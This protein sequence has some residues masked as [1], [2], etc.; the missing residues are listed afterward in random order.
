VRNSA[1]V[2][3]IVTSKAS[4]RVV[5]SGIN[6]V[7]SA[8]RVNSSAIRRDVVGVHPSLLG[9]AGCGGGVAGRDVCVSGCAVRS[10]T[11]AGGSS[12]VVVGAQAVGA[13]AWG[14]GL[15]G[16]I[17]RG[18]VRGGAVVGGSVV[19]G[20]GGGLSVVVLVVELV[21]DLVHETHDGG[22]VVVLVLLFWWVCWCWYCSGWCLY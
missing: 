21:G 1:R 15:V 18:D 17:G 3:L 8:G 16:V 10:V 2:V 4:S 14:G 13:G 22:L 19:G 5:D 20:G 9:H 12:A 6:A 11:T 7:G